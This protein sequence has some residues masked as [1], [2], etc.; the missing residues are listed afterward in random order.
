MRQP[1]FQE[2]CEA[3][4]HNRFATWPKTLQEE[5]ILTKDASGWTPL[6]V[7]ALNG[8]FDQIPTYLLT[9]TRLLTED[10]WAWSPLNE[11]AEKGHLDKVPI[12]IRASTLSKLL[13]L[14]KMPEE[15][16]K[17]IREEIAKQ[18]LG[19]LLQN[20]RHPDL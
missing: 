7:A 16:R 9:E 18:K 3:I 13:Q 1:T 8:R 6:H 15:S 5:A 19:A 17:W 20:A 2:T 4:N 12:R 14:Q 11:A 10:C